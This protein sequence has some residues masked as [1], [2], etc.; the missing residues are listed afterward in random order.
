MFW[1]LSRYQYTI[2]GVL[3]QIMSLFGSAF[4]R[5]V[6][7]F[8]LLSL[9]QFSILISSWNLFIF[10]IEGHFPNITIP[11]ERPVQ[12]SPGDW[13]QPTGERT[14][15]CIPALFV[16]RRVDC[17]RLELFLG[18][19]SLGHLKGGLRHPKWKTFGTMFGW[20]IWLQRLDTPKMETF[21]AIL[22]DYDV[23]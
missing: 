13:L 18:H 2:Y 1:I 22:F 11:K 9:G 16:P 8:Y 6:P 5:L 15:L 12:I 19:V 23:G 21:G 3:R 14:C 20:A 7:S 4:A 10:N 17:S